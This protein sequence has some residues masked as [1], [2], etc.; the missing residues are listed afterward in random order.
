MLIINM[1][2]YMSIVAPAAFET[3][4]NGFMPDLWLPLRPLTDPNPLDSRG[5]RSFPA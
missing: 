5:M 2:R 1:S 3:H 4:Q